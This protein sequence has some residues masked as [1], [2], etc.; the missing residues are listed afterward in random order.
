MRVSVYDMLVSSS[1]CFIGLFV[2]KLKAWAVCS[3][4]PYSIYM[5]NVLGHTKVDNE[6]L[7]E[8]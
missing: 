6:N 7:K 4:R 8:S 2:P 5:S 3:N 1:L